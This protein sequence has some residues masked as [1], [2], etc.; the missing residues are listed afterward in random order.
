MSEEQ[1]GSAQLEEVSGAG[2][3]ARKPETILKHAAAR[4]TKWTVDDL[5]DLADE[6]ELAAE[7]LDT[8]DADSLIR[9][10]LGGHRNM[11]AGG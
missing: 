9:R 10:G 8:K 5:F 3:M 6:I 11:S 7:R 4:K 2:L 1:T